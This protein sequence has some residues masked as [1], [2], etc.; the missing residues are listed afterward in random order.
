MTQS[1]LLEIIDFFT[2]NFIAEI[3]LSEGRLSVNTEIFAVLFVKNGLTYC[4]NYS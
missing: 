1:C 3:L 4:K 2:N